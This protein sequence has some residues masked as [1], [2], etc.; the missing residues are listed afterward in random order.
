MSNLFQSSELLCLACTSCTLG[1]KP[2]MFH[3]FSFP[4][5]REDWQTKQKRD[6]ERDAGAKGAY[7]THL[8]L[9]LFKYLGR[10][11]NESYGPGLKL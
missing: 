5:F 2:A 4:T 3:G 11:L 8:I 10:E 6:T 1:A 9:L 7:Q